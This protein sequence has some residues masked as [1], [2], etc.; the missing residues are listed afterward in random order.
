VLHPRRGLPPAHHAPPTRC[1]HCLPDAHGETQVRDRF[2]NN[3]EVD[4]YDAQELKIDVRVTGQSNG[5]VFS[6]VC[7]LTF[8]RG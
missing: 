2:G 1:T 8:T 3:K 4:F 6:Q 7:T 5:I